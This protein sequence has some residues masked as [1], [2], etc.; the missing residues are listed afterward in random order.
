L[1]PGRLSCH[2]H[3]EGE[4]FAVMHDP[5]GYALTDRTLHVNA[6][7]LLVSF[8]EEMTEEEMRKIIASSSSE[9][10]LAD[11][12][13]K[14]IEQMDKDSF[15]LSER[16]VELK[17]RKDME[18]LALEARPSICAGSSYPDN[19]K[20]IN[21]WLS[22]LFNAVD[23]TQY[24][25]SAKAIVAPHLDFRLGE[26]LDTAYASAY[27]SIANSE[28][29]VYV[30]LG[31]SHNI[32][33]DYF[34]FTEKDYETPLG[35]A[36]ID[37][38]LISGIDEILGDYM[39]IDDLSHKIEHSVEYQ[40]VLLQHYFGKDIKILPILTGSLYG[41]LEQNDSEIT[42]I[43]YNK[44][45]ETIKA[46]LSKQN[47]KAVFI[48]SADLAHIGRKFGDEFDAANKLEELE[49]AD[50]AMLNELTSDSESAFLKNIFACQDQWKVCGLA[51]I[52]A[53]AKLADYKKAEMLNYNIWNEQETKSA[54]SFAALKFV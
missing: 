30:I 45:L 51:P 47:K 14:L 21:E 1:V 29:D 17:T 32:S 46:T 5:F 20:E 48:A 35:K 9:P 52:T 54:V 25:D 11:H 36:E 43:R 10:E 2:Y 34:M 15:M 53:A 33:N 41:E 24:T 12:F 4:I 22:K 7:N 50:L 49:K 37:M 44:I 27:H 3:H 26:A 13:W 23:K 19:E 40:V 31:T 16:F 8:A 18:Y 28:A 38:E 6:Y 39:T 42:S